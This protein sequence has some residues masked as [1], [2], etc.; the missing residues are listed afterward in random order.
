M[1]QIRKVNDLEEEMKT[2]LI[3][4]LPQNGVTLNPPYLRKLVD[5]MISDFQIFLYPPTRDEQQ[6]SLEEWNSSLCI[7]LEK[8]LLQRYPKIATI[9]Q[10]LKDEIVRI[11]EAFSLDYFLD[12]EQTQYAMENHINVNE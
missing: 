2:S 11:V 3:D 8:S 6:K 9:D 1:K 4:V 5:N 12:V 7:C 10:P